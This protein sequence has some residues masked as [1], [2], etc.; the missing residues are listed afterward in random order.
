MLTP[1]STAAAQRRA[2]AVLPKGIEDMK[3]G[4]DELD[5]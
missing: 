3:E 1:L 2:A 5:L 4:E